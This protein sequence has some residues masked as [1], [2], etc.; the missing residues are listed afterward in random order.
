MTFR[1]SYSVELSNA[2]SAKSFL[3]SIILLTPNFMARE[4]DTRREN[5]EIGRVHNMS[6][7]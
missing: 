5:E 1:S 7:V 6:R 2:R 3:F 4:T